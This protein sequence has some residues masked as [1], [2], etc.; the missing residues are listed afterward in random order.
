MEG[1]T[2]KV[3]IEL[4]INDRIF[5]FDHVNIL[6]TIHMSCSTRIST[7]MLYMKI[8]DSS[9]WLS[10]TQDLLD[11][12]PISITYIVQGV[13]TTRQFRLHSFKEQLAPSG[14]SYTIDGY[15]D[16][17]PYWL[18]TTSDPIT[19][20]SNFVIES[21]AN[22]CQITYAGTKTADS[23]T[24]IPM[25]KRYHQFAHDV[26]SHGFVDE[27]SCMQLAYDLDDVLIYSNVAENKDV[28]KTFL[29]A[30]YDEKTYTVTD[31]QPK[32]KSGLMNAISGYAEEQHE[33]SIL[34]LTPTVTNKASVKS[35]TSKLL[36]NKGIYNTINKQGKVFYRPINAGNTHE[37]YWLA[38]YQN[39]RLSN[40]Y[41]FGMDLVIAQPST[42]VR[43]LDFI[44]YEARLQDGQ[45]TAYSGKYLVTARVVYIQ[46]NNYYEKFEVSRQGVNAP[47]ETQL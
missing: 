38:Y 7:P 5:P 36:M 35:L 18:M 37:N 11:G 42:N 16:T 20:S 39:K 27:Q 1:F 15:L 22:T 40:L 45:I 25:N 6:E 10:K 34:T 14:V 12:T 17:V 47:V 31:F 24:W 23:M 3:Q 2:D 26:A 9:N 46:G 19:G 4:M 28:K 43:L 13:K 30:K 8:I 32:A 33:Q 44:N 41:S 21:I 29:T